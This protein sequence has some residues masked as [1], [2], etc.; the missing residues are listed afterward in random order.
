MTKERLESLSRIASLYFEERLT[1]EQVATRTGYSRSMVSRLL[2]EARKRGV[3]EIRVHHSLERC[4][5]LE[6][7]LQKHFGL[8]AVRVL[9]GGASNPGE[10]MARLGMLGARLIEELVREN[11]TIAVSWGGTLSQAIDAL[12][13]KP[14]PSIYVVQMV[15]LLGASDP[16]IDGSDVARR[17]ARAFSGRYSILPAPLIANNE[18]TKQALLADQRVHRVLEIAGHADLA[19]VGIGTL[20]LEHCTLLQDGYLTKAQVNQLRRSNVVGDTGCIFFDQS[21]QTVMTS[22]TRRVVGIDEPT[23]R[24]IP[25]RLGIAGGS[26]KILPIVGALRSGLVNVLVTDETAA[27]GVLTAVEETPRRARRKRRAC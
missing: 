4:A 13:P 7:A 1:Q 15:G 24:A 22:L 2:T 18:A 8:A 20:E 10:T 19:I 12:R 16:R 27:N 11:M 25:T 21:G 26:S 14:F 17:M 6:Q 9:S 3:V 23:M 5:D